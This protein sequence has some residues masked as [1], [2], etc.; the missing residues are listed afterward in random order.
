MP[1]SDRPVNS[2]IRSLIRDL[3][4]PSVVLDL[5]GRVQI[6]NTAAERLFGW[7]EWE[8]QGSSLPI[9][10]KN[11][12]DESLLLHRIV[13][14][15]NA[16]T[17]LDLIRQ[18]KDGSTVNVSLSASPVR[19]EAGEVIGILGVL[20]PVRQPAGME[21]PVGQQTAG[22][23]EREESRKAEQRRQRG[24]LGHRT[25]AVLG[26]AWTSCRSPSSAES[27]RPDRRE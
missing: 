26:A 12:R 21:P 9:V 1:S 15:G 25:V 18:K 11:K 22:Q 2:A 5:D 4:L 7:S 13:A 23:Q 10:P 17:G 20:E 27:T 8:V 19:N 6:W 16:Y 14:R 3:A 24:C